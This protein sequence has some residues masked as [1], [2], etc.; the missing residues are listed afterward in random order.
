[1]CEGMHGHYVVS[2]KNQFGRRMERC[3]GVVGEGFAAPTSLRPH[4]SPPKPFDPE[5]RFLCYFEHTYDLGGS[6]QC[7][8]SAPC[9][10]DRKCEF[11]RCKE[12]AAG[13]GLERQE[14]GTPGKIFSRETSV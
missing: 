9:F 4:T 11:L 2:G 6:I 3:D 10:L 13:K 5:N 12:G 8:T 7:A 1:M 14:V